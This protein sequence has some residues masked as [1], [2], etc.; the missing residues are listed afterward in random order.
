MY[1]TV[2]AS[3][4]LVAVSGH[5][6][7][8]VPPA[9]NVQSYGT[10]NQYCPHCFNAGGTGAVSAAS[11]GVFLWPETSE[12]ASRHGLC[13]DPAGSTDHMTGGALYTPDIVG[14]FMAGG[15]IN[16]EILVT[17]HHNG[18]FEFS[19]CDKSDLVDP[20]GSI[21]QECLDQHTLLRSP[22]HE[23]TDSHLIDPAYPGRYYLDPKCSKPIEYNDEFYIDAQKVTMTYDLPNVVSNFA[24]LQWW[25][26]PAAHTR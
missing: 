1:S 24:V 25:Q 5:G 17:A 13:G 22:E 20:S 19:L 8:T 9:R 26:V 23:A 21:T 2:I 18:H 7:M 11:G 6:F 4:L 10:A 15:K 3:S 16:I 12:T 14:T